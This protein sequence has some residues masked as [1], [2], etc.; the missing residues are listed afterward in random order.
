MDFALGSSGEWAQFEVTLLSF[1]PQAARVKV[2]LRPA[3]W[4]VAGDLTGTA[5]FD[6]IEFVGV[7]VSD[8]MH[9]EWL[10]HEGPVWVW[11]APLESKVRREH[12]LPLDARRAEAVQIAAGGGEYEPFQIV[13]VADGQDSL[14]SVVVSDLVCDTGLLP[15][16]DVTIR[17]V[18]YVDVVEPTD[19]GSV[20]GPMPDPLPLLENDSHTS[21]TARS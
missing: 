8:T 20:T 7:D 21:H 10:R 4:T 18:A 9:G 2:L 13:L 11:R 3:R 16:A 5:W 12:V 14:T 19:W 15:G 6:D 17:E 1:Q